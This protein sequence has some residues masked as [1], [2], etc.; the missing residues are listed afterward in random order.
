MS[1]SL[2]S[3]YFRETDLLDTPPLHKL[4]HN[5]WLLINHIQFRQRGE[6][7]TFLSTLFCYNA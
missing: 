5:Y 6:D 2:K 4:V 1:L 7:A 3:K